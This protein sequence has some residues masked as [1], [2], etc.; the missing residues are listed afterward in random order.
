MTHTAR[1]WNAWYRVLSVVSLVNNISLEKRGNIS[2]GPRD[3]V[4]GSPV[5]VVLKGPRPKRFEE[6]KRLS[7]RWSQGCQE[8]KCLDPRWSQRVQG[9]EMFGSSRVPRSL[10]ADMTKPHEYR[11][12]RPN[13]NIRTYACTRRFAQRVVP[14]ATLGYEEEWNGTDDPN[15]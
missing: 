9:A 15:N 6:A 7:P 2:L 3:P 8:L 5:P 12:K 4:G 10:G 11:D 1:I 13:N 14:P